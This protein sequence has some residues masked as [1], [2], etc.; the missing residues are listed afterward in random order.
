M[1]PIIE[2]II[3][4]N[5]YLIL[6]YLLLKFEWCQ[7]YCQLIDQLIQLNTLSYKESIIYNTYS[8]EF[9][10]STTIKLEIYLKIHQMNSFMNKVVS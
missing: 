6:A 7:I 9:N 10:T 2:R 8:T 1:T 3:V 4:N 5:G